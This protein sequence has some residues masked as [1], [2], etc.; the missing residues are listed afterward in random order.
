MIPQHYDPTRYLDGLENG[1]DRL[2]KMRIAAE[3][4]LETMQEESERLSEVGVFKD[5]DTLKEWETKRKGNSIWESPI[6]SMS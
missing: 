3:A 2:A 1:Y 4:M 5:C 6:G